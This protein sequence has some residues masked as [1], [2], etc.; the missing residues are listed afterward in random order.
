MESVKKKVM[1]AADE[2]LLAANPLSPLKVSVHFGV[3]RLSS[4]IG[5]TIRN[6]IYNK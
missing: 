2:V 3:Y 4:V 6:F 1:K 5:M